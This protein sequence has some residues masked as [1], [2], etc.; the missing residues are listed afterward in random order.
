MLYFWYLLSWILNTWSCTLSWWRSLINV[1]VNVMYLKGQFFRT[2]WHKLI[3]KLPDVV[4]RYN[5]TFE[6]RETLFL[7]DKMID[8]C[9]LRYGV[10]KLTYVTNYSKKPLLASYSTGKVGDHRILIKTSH[11]YHQQVVQSVVELS[12]ITSRQNEALS[13]LLR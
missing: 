9:Y 12:D 1:Q 3:E 5:D 11:F 7:C 8:F 13:I 10:N 2:N 4:D 6:N